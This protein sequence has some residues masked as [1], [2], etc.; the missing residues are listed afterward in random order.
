MIDQENIGDKRFITE[1]SSSV[2][3]LLIVRDWDRKIESLNNNPQISSILSNMGFDLSTLFSLLTSEFPN[4]TKF[5]E[6]K[7][8]SGEKIEEVATERLIVNGRP[9]ERLLVIAYPSLAN[10]PSGK[11][12]QFESGGEAI[13]VTDGEAEITFASRVSHDTISQSDLVVEK[14][15]K[16]DL[17]LSVD[18]PNNWTAVLG[19]RFTFLY[20]VGNPSGAQRYGDVPKKSVSVVKADY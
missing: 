9:L 1:V 18:T 19:N 10:N 13:L 2:K 6:V 12:T 7:N 16:G 4:N 20:F 8:S 5:E 3:P 14:V 15:K 17:I 11:M